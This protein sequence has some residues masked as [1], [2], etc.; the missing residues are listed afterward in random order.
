VVTVLE[1]ELARCTGI[2]EYVLLVPTLDDNGKGVPRGKACKNDNTPLL[3]ALADVGASS[4]PD[5]QVH[6]LFFLGISPL[7]LLTRSD[8]ARSPV[9]AADRRAV[10]VKILDAL[11][12]ATICDWHGARWWAVEFIGESQT[13]VGGNQVFPIRDARE[14]LR[15]DSL[16]EC[17]KRTSWPIAFIALKSCIIRVDVGP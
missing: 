8:G 14:S 2:G 13:T 4:I 5:F 16:Q 9:D 7:P 17:T 12:S 10:Q 3:E 6:G 1:I 15:C 11:P